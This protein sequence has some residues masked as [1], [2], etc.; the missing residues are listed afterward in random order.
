MEKEEQYLLQLR[1]IFFANEIHPDEYQLERMARY[2][3][4]VVNKNQIVNLISRKD[5]DHIIENHIFIS[6]L[7]SEHMPNKVSRFLDIGTGGGFPGIPLSIIRPMLRGVLVDSTNKKIDA[8]SEFIK[9]LKLGK[10]IAENS[11]VESEDFKIKYANKF[12]LIVT[13]ATVPLV[14]LFRYALP[15][16]KDKAYIMAIKGGDLTEEFN[17]AKTKYGAYIKKHTTFE[18]AYKPSNVRNAKDK[19]L[20][21]LE[22]SK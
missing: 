13:R 5:E 21:L 14:I 12:D 17:T 3:D 1:K 7:I 18:L 15:L 6:A 8:V 2:A 19:K 16:I 20:V 9:T 10:L 4:L 11:R 22:L